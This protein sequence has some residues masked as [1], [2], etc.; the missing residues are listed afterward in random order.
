MLHK[1]K[2][3]LGITQIAV[4]LILVIGLVGG[5][6][7]V[8]YTT[9]NL[10]PKAAYEDPTSSSLV[11]K[12]QYDVPVKIQ[13]GDILGGGFVLSDITKEAGFVTTLKTSEEVITA[14][15]DPKKVDEEKEEELARVVFKKMAD[16]PQYYPFLKTLMYLLANEMN[17]VSNTP[18]IDSRY[19]MCDYI[20]EKVLEEIGVNKTSLYGE[21]GRV[22]GCSEQP[23]SPQQLGVV[24]GRP[25]REGVKFYKIPARHLLTFLELAIQVQEKREVL[26]DPQNLAYHVVPFVGPYL[27]AIHTPGLDPKEVHGKIALFGAVDA[28]VMYFGGAV[29]GVTGVGI[30]AVLPA[31]VRTTISDVTIYVGERVIGR[32]LPE[33]VMKLTE[34]QLFETL[35]ETAQRESLKEGQKFSIKAVVGHKQIPHTSVEEAKNNSNNTTEFNSNKCTDC[36]STGVN[37]KEEGIAWGDLDKDKASW[38]SCAQR[39][40]NKIYGESFSAD[41]DRYRVC[42]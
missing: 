27:E 19:T 18:H 30:A 29:V 25:H 20:P 36:D 31:A 17:T 41:N 12:N 4:L 34:R 23:P 13:S 21:G 8:N 6:Y 39:Y 35:V 32:V 11:S 42:F 24:Y 22:L 9:T 2:N 1:S 26:L 14:E 5:Y 33:G 3:Q 16:D 15:F 37:C 7:L 10:K 28:V 38:C 40:A